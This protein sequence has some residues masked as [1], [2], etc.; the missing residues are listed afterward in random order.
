M[1]VT[2]MSV[3]TLFSQDKTPG[4][5]LNHDSSGKK[6]YDEDYLKT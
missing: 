6:K 5:A 2:V 1:D 3:F 4:K